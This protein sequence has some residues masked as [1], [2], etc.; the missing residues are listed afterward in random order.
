LVVVNPNLQRKENAHNF[1]VWLRPQGR[2]VPP[3]FFMFLKK[4]NGS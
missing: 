2:D 3:G 4:P 1:F